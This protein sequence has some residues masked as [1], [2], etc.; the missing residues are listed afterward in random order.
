M[1]TANFGFGSDAVTACGHVSSLVLRDQAN[2]ALFVAS[3][4]Y[5]LAI[6]L[7]TAVFQ[8]GIKVCAHV[9][10]LIRS[11][12]Q[13]QDRILPWF[14]FSNLED[15]MVFVHVF[16]SVVFLLTILVTANAQRQSNMLVRRLWTCSF[17]IL[18]I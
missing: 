16:P 12:V 7:V 15:V 18:V 10:G 2:A 13:R 8:K 17:I 5:K 3:P 1:C 14:Q 11:F 4:S 6:A 9:V